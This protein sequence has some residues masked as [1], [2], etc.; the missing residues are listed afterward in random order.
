MFE[1]STTVLTLLDVAVT[2]PSST[3]VD[4]E[5]A[6]ALK[7]DRHSDTTTPSDTPNCMH[8]PETV[9]LLLVTRA[10]P[11]LP[12]TSAVKKVSS[13]TGEPMTQGC[14]TAVEDC[15]HSVAVVLQSS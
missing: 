4:E 8:W 10:T 13:V 6:R 12:T 2:A 7:S 1:P 9:A 14:T 5:L 11:V 3:T 15:E